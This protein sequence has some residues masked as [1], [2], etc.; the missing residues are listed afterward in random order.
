MREAMLINANDGNE[1]NG[2]HKKKK[3][4]DCDSLSK[5]RWNVGVVVR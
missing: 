5:M 3:M 4:Y 2:E 1:M